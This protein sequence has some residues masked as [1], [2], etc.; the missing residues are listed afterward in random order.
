MRTTIHIDDHLLTRVKEVAARTGKTMTAVIEDA[1][2]LSLE[3]KQPRERKVVRL[4][5]V[6]GKGPR[7]GVD[8]DDTA[9]ILEFMERNK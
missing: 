1:L 2:R 4:T 9:S 8:L 3:R 5:T 7:K 6:G